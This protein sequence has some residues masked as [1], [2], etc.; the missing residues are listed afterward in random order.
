VG[1][2]TVTISVTDGNDG[3]DSRQFDI[4]VINVND[5]P[6]ITTFDII[7]VEQDKKYIRNY[8]AED[9]DMND[10][11]QWLLE[12]NASFLSIE[13]QTGTLSGTPTYSDV[14]SYFVNV[15]VWDRSD[16]FDFHNFTL[17]VEDIDDIPIWLD[18]PSDS[19]ITHG[20]MF[21]YNV[22]AI[23]PDIGGYVEY[24]VSTKP[25]SDMKIDKG[26]GL[27]EWRADI[28]VFEE[29][30]YDLKVTITIADG[31]NQNTHIFILTIIPTGSPEVINLRPLS[32]QKTS[33]SLT[34]LTWI[35]SDPEDETLVYDVYLHQTEA[36]IVGLREEALFAEDVPDPWLNLTDLEPGKTYYWTVRPH[37]GCSYGECMDGVQSFG[38]NYK[39]TFKTIK[40]QVTN[41]GV[42]F[43]F[44][45]SATDQDT[46]DQAILF[47]SLLEAPS[48][49]TINEATGMIRW[50]PNNDQVMLH[51]V[52]VQVSDGIEE[53][54]TTFE[55]DVNE[56]TSSSS[57]MLI[58]IVAAVIIG[59]LILI[60]IIFLVRKKHTMDEEALKKGE[61]ERETL[62]KERE[63]EYASYEELYGVPAPEKEEKG[64]TTT[65]LK[66][67]IHDQI[68]ELEEEE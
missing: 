41:A 64:M 7:T 56:G 25:D 33:S 40:D 19:T 44:K 63:E 39:P 9:I 3:W 53:S 58:I 37:D 49:M 12:T 11:L 45:I 20:Q 32:G 67:Y 30:P 35:G 22:S 57:T 29:E 66:D 1:T 23:D 36:F 59:I 14:G 43:K 61:E 4:T 62:D 48:G 15:S 21:S 68:E 60:G 51:T 13:S 50:T 26:T 38:V 55:I 24:S 6:I 17:T 31:S 47:Y 28:N 16:A 34:K 2:N 27:L 54:T 18:I 10:E 42:D 5:P 52:T 8:A 65:E 46:E